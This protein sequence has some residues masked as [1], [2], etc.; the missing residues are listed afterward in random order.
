MATRGDLPMSRSSNASQQ[1][2]KPLSTN[3]L[4]AHLRHDCG[5]SINGSSDK[6]KLQN[7]GYYHGYKGYR[8]F[9]EE[10]TRLPITDF[11][12]LYRLF[13]FDNQLKATFYPW[14]MR[15]ETALRSCILESICSYAITHHISVSYDSVCKNCFDASEKDKYSQL[16]FLAN[17]IARNTGKEGKAVVSH[18]TETSRNVPIWA[19]AEVL[20]LGEFGTIYGCLSHDIKDDIYQKLSMPKRTWSGN[21]IPKQDKKDH[22]LSFINALTALRNSVAHDNVIVDARFAIRNA[23]GKETQTYF[24]KQFG[25]NSVKFSDLPDYMLLICFFMHSLSFTK[26]DCK[27]FIRS[28]EQVLS[29]FSNNHICNVMIGKSN[30]LKIK[31]ARSYISSK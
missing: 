18:F 14:L 22:L 3:S 6:R 30:S 16:S 27:S 23:P 5:I 4:M 20:T 24:A 7:I 31:A 17:K 12:D 8:F 2:F 13:L 19:L 21:N 10:R 15:T 25:L 9:K 1:E 28:Y 11:S 26:T 29:D